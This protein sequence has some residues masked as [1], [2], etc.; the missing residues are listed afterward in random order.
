MSVKIDDSQCEFSLWCGVDVN[1]I[2]DD[3]YKKNR[4]NG[5]DFEL[6]MLIKY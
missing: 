5:F 6:G 4:I 2:I 3:N 1:R